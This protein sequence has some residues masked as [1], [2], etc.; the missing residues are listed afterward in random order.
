MSKPMVITLPGL[1]L[2]LDCWPFER[3]ALPDHHSAWNDFLSSARISLI[4]KIPLFF[5]TA[6]AAIITVVSQHRGGAVGHTAVLP[7]GFRIENA[8]LSYVLYVVKAFWPVRLTRKGA[9]LFL[10]CSFLALLFFL[11]PSFVGDGVLTAISS[12]DGFGTLPLCSL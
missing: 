11:S 3:I 1:L 12:S 2:L 6:A 4:E 9:F 7:L 5:I 8:L 10:S